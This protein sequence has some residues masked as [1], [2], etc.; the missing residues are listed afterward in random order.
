MVL[1]FPGQGI[2]LKAFGNDVLAEHNA[3]QVF[4][5]LIKGDEQK[6]QAQSEVSLRGFSLMHLITK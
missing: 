3:A 1:F 5:W 6:T 4:V 2:S